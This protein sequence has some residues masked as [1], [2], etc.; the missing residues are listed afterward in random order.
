MTK[1]QERIQKSSHLLNVIFICALLDPFLHMLQKLLMAVGLLCGHIPFVER[2]IQQTPNATAFH[3]A[4]FNFASILCYA[5]IFAAYY[6]IHCIFRDISQEY[7]PFRTIHTKRLRWV[8]VLFTAC[9]IFESVLNHWAVWVNTGVLNWSFR[10]EGKYIFP[11]LIF[12]FSFILDYACQLQAEADT[13][14]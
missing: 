14:L 12:S 4:M 7:T 2:L 10:L 6:L 13:T 9:F 5:L 3:G 8:G 1:L 11:L